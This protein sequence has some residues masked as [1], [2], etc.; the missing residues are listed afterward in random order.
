MTDPRPTRPVHVAQL[1]R[2]PHRNEQ[3]SIERVFAT[4]RAAMPADVRVSVVEASERSHGVL[5]RVRSV[6]AARQAV[7]RLDADVEHVT[8]DVH[9]L[10]FGLH[11]R[12]TVLTIHDTEFMDRA[13]TLKRWIYRALWLRL[14]VARAAAITVVSAQTGADLVRHAPRAATKIRIVP[15]PLP[16]GYAPEAKPF[17]ASRPTIL[18]I[19]TRPNKNLERVVAALEGIDCRLWILGPL[20]PH[21]VGALERAGVDYEQWSDLADHE[22]VARYRDCD[23]VVFAST[24]EGFGLPIIEANAIGRPVVTSAIEPMR[25]VAGD[26]AELVDPTDV[27]SIRAGI[28]RVIDDATHRESLVTRGFLNAQRFGANEVAR[29]YRDV[30]LDVAERAGRTR[31]R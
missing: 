11:A 30:Y 12:R 22:V 28:G 10:V 31:R 29:A 21:Q 1:T 7:R 2:R 24:R 3:F 25:G 16:A 14:P 15:N 4:V 9:F 13:S 26:A 19:G 23:L 6:L 27:A 18:Q 8:G 17:P 20:A 5:P